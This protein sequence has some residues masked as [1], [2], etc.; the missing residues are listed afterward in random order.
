M[1]YEHTFTVGATSVSDF[2][3]FLFLYFSNRF[4]GCMDLATGRLMWEDGAKHLGSGNLP[5]PLEM[6]DGRLI[7]GSE[8]VQAVDPATGKAAWKIE[9][10]GKVT[11]LFVHDGLAVA[12]GQN[13]DGGDGHSE[14]SRALACEDLWSYDKSSLG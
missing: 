2:G 5:L 10:L 1:E 6:A 13:E 7:Y 8:N 3:G 12:L 14:R 9:K 11:G 4:L